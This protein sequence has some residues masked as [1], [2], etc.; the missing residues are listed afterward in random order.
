MTR[1]WGLIQLMTLPEVGV[2][3]RSTRKGSIKHDPKLGFDTI[4]GW[5]I[6]RSTRSWVGN[7][8]TRGWGLI[9]LMTLPEVGVTV[10]STRKGSII[11]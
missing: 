11:A 7:G 8:M 9:Q 5:I 3:V 6:I 1:S 10:R 4:G 2:T